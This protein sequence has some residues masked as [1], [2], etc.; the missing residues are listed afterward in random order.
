MTNAEYEKFAGKLIVGTIV[1]VT[2]LICVTCL[3]AVCDDI[4]GH[5]I[6]FPAI[7]GGIVTTWMMAAGRTHKTGDGV[8]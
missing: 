5:W 6:A 2:S 8:S 4:S 7:I 3:I 1:A